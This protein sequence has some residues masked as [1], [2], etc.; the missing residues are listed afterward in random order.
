MQAGLGSSAAATVAG[1]RLYDTMVSGMARDLISGRH[2]D[3]R[4]S[5][6]RR[7]RAP[8]RADH[9]LR[10]RRW[11]CAGRL[12]AVA[13][14]GPVR[15][16]DAGGTSQARRTR[17]ASC[18]RRSRGRTPSST[19]SVWRCCSRRCSSIVRSCCAKRCATAGTSR[20]GRHSC[21]AST[22]A[23]ALE[24]PNLPRR[25]PQR[26]RASRRGAASPAS[27]R[28]DSKPSCC[29]AIY[30]ADRTCRATSRPSVRAHNGRPTRQEFPT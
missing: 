7:R 4:P 9:G 13:G 5:R 22:E 12:G 8:G 27:V 23:L 14:A 21:P 18:P 6:Q 2:G 11:A 26:R 20:I 25:L 10:V 24:H 1:L 17:G 3:R 16:G 15:D 29:Q 19:C 30:A 28:R